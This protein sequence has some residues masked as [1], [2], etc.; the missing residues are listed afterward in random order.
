MVV[1]HQITPGIDNQKTAAA[2]RDGAWWMLQIEACF[3]LQG[4]ESDSRIP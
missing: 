2:A 3:T 4:W 1:F